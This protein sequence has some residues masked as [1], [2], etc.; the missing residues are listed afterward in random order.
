MGG[1]PCGCLGCDC[2]CSDCIDDKA[3]P[4]FKVVLSGIL[5][6]NEADDLNHNGMT[7][8]T[9]DN[10]QSCDGCDDLNGTHILHHAGAYRGELTAPRGKCNPITTTTYCYWYPPGL[11]D[12]YP[13]DGGIEIC[14]DEETTW[15]GDSTGR[16]VTGHVM[17][18]VGRGFSG[19]N[20]WGCQWAEN[21][22]SPGYTV[23]VWFPDWCDG[24]T[25]YFMC[26][27]SEIYDTAG[28]HFYGVG[29]E[30]DGENCCTVVDLAL[31]QYCQA[32]TPAMDP[33]FPAYGFRR[34]CSGRDGATATITALSP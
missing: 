27:L 23:S 7:Q 33:D 31:D 17:L 4:R 14:E 32:N 19:F 20:D 16:Q 6:A 2:V 1:F 18:T 9:A 3:P 10:L 8:E 21:M 29:Q 34:I 28:L 25:N 13:S 15:P 22:G 30:Y 11:L 12:T 24:G 26:S 5:P